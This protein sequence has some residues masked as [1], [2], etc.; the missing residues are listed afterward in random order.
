ME[1]RPYTLS[2]RNL[3]SVYYIVPCALI[4]ALCDHW[5]F[6]GTVRAALPSDI[7]TLF[8]YVLFLNIPHLIASLF[9]FAEGAYLRFYARTVAVLGVLLLGYA[10]ILSESY[11]AAFLLFVLYTEYHVMNQQ[12]GIASAYI[13]KAVRGYALWRYLGMAVMLF[14]YVQGLFDG[15]AVS[16]QIVSGV[17]LVLWVATSAFALLT[18][19]IYRQIER[20]EGRFFVIAI[21]GALM[22]GVVLMLMGYGLFAV[23]IHRFVHDITAFMVYLTHDTNRAHVSSGIE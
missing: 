3:L 5:L 23:L 18:P 11:L 8:V 6:A 10:W 7:N 15:T 21:S 9:S 4:V 22:G 17:S 16:S 20:Q 2:F 12:A 19:Y 14:P 13:R 1:V